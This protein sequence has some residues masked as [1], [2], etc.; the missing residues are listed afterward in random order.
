MAQTQTDKVIA[1]LVRPHKMIRFYD[2]GSGP[3]REAF[4]HIAVVEHKALGSV[5]EREISLT[6]FY[7]LRKAGRIV[8]SHSGHGFA[9]QADYYQLAE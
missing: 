2:H 3:Q 5:R 9:D 8:F 1:D 4:A 7:R 6:I